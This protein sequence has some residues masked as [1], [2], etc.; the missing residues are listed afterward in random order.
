MHL[1]QEMR[2][3]L[4]LHC[5]LSFSLM[6]LH[7]FCGFA[8]TIIL[9]L[10]ICSQDRAVLHIALRN[11]SNRPIMVDGKDVSSVIIITTLV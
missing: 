2:V 9:L 5:S 4:L 7:V 10:A 6:S 8:A 11:R 1:E 3:A